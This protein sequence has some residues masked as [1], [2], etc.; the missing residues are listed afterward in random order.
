[1]N[2]PT[3]QSESYSDSAGRTYSLPPARRD[4]H[5]QWQNDQ[6]RTALQSSRSNQST[7]RVDA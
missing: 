4:A 5:C 7:I 3:L 6:E 1:M 2:K